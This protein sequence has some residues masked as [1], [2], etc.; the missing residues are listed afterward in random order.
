MFLA[1][2]LEDLFLWYLFCR[3]LNSLSKNSLKLTF[4]FC[5]IIKSLS[6]KFLIISP[7]FCSQNNVKYFEK[8]IVVLQM[9]ELQQTDPFYSADDL[10]NRK[11]LKDTRF[12]ARL[13]KHQF[14]SCIHLPS[15]V[16]D[17]GSVLLSFFDALSDV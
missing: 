3:I 5:S 7:N 11:V 10:F 17:F 6:A 1:S 2:Q 9:A 13:Q 15:D 16:V 4:S 14:A 8:L 12:P